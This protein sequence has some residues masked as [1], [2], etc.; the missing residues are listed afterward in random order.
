MDRIQSIVYSA[1][2]LAV[3]AGVLGLIAL[4]VR[5]E[6]DLDRAL[7]TIQSKQYVDLTHGFSPDTPVWSGFGQAKPGDSIGW[8]PRSP[9]R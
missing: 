8:A 9:A 5:A 7:R 2:R 3:V 6:T 1:L 4:P